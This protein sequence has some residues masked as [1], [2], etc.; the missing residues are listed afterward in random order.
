MLEIQFKKQA[1]K[2]LKRIQPKMRQ[3]VLDAI[4]KLAEDPKRT[5]LDI[6][7]LTGSNYL[8]MRVGEYRVVF[9]LDGVIVNI[10]RIAPRGSVY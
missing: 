8:R 7:L 6:K 5:D 3:R 9:S 2:E 4:E 10:E 1:I